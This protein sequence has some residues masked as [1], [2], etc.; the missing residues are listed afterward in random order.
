MH[1]IDAIE[2]KKHF[3]KKFDK[4]L[5]NEEIIKDYHI[6]Y[7]SLSNNLT[8]GVPTV[9]IILFILLMTVNIKVGVLVEFATNVGI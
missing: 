3:N 9:P 6:Q 5:L 2:P 8:F 7:N 1:L 4:I